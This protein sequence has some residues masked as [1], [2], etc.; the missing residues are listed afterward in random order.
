MGRE[1]QEPTD[2][3]AIS[4][5]RRAVWLGLEP[6]GGGSSSSPPTFAAQ[7][8]EYTSVHFKG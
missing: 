3:K 1:G 5:T 4:G 6:E 7:G 8:F 2:Q